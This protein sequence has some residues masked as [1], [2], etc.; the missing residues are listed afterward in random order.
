MHHPFLNKNEIPKEKNKTYHNHSLISSQ[1]LKQE[2]VEEMVEC[3]FY[4]EYC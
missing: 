1:P 2:Q 4:L 3:G